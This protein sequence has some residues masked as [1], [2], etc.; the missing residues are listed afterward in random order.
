MILKLVERTYYTNNYCLVTNRYFSNNKEMFTYL[1]NLSTNLKNDKLKTFTNFVNEKVYTFKN[2]N[3]DIIDDSFKGGVLKHE[4]ITKVEVSC[5][6]V[7]PKTVFFI[8]VERGN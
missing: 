6:Y 2:Y 5:Y 7:S 1:A 8:R 4:Q 3:K